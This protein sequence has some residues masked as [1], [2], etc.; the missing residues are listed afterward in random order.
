MMSTRYFIATI[1]LGFSSICL[2]AQ[3]KLSDTQPA[4]SLCQD[5][6]KKACSFV[7]K[8]I[9]YKYNSQSRDALFRPGQKSKLTFT[10][11]KG[12]DYRL[13]FAEEDKILQSGAVSF[14]IIDSRTKKELFNSEDENAT[15]LEF[16]CDSNINLTIEI[17]LP[18]NTAETF[19]KVLYGCFGFLLESRPTLNTG[20]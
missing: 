1:L 13:T 15:E 3:V 16:I 14:R 2:H 7:K 4:A 11:H 17:Q 12:Y 8:D 5:F 18:E 20:F 19:G 6:H 10:A 9:N